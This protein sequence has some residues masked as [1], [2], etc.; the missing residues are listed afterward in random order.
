MK[1]GAAVL[2]ITD[3]NVSFDGP[4]DPEFN[5]FIGEEFTQ[6]RERIRTFM[7]AQCRQMDQLRAAAMRGDE[8]AMNSLL[9]KEKSRSAFQVAL[10]A[11]R[12]SLES[13]FNGLD[14]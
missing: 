2:K 13:S 7:R 12:A 10:R 8:K 5:K 1:E 4:L 9:L 11:G 14:A 6:L 3:S